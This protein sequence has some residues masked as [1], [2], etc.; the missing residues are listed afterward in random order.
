MKKDKSKSSWTSLLLR[1]FVTR[2]ITFFHDSNPSGI[3]DYLAQIFESDSA[4]CIGPQSQS[5]QSALHRRVKKTKCLKLCDAS[6]L[7]SSSAVS[8]TLRSQHYQTFWSNISSNLKPNSKIL[9]PVYQRPEWVRTWEKLEV[10]NLVAH[11]L[12]GYTS[13]RR[14]GTKHLSTKQLMTKPKQQNTSLH[15]TYNVKICKDMSNAAIQ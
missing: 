4:V 10:E 7:E 9:K 13:K 8:C 2:F 14:L 5:L 6:Y 11:S 15:N 12:Q 3:F 1:E